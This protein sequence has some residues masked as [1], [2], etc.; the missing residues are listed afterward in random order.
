M[1]L[2]ARVEAEFRSKSRY[3]GRIR[4]LQA[5]RKRQGDRPDLDHQDCER[6]E[7]HGWVRLDS[8]WEAVE[9][10]KNRSFWSDLKHLCDHGLIESSREVLPEEVGYG[11]DI[12]YRLTSKGRKKCGTSG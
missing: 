8:M 11:T 3:E 6:P 9:D 2:A 1:H 7:L 4:I 12:L 5:I 10:D